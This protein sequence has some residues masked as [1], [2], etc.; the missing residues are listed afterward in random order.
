ML[1]LE[2]QVS[3]LAPSQRLRELGVKQESL[4]VWHE[5]KNA[6][7]VI[8][9]RKNEAEI[10]AF[11]VAE[12]GNAL[13]EVDPDVLQMAYNVVFNVEGSRFITPTGLQILLTSPDLCAKMLIYL[14]ENKL[15]TV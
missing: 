7:S 14:L 11:T 12:L 1:S 13:S 15:I 8:Y 4:F 9:G 6:P 5:F 10:S 2:N 3:S